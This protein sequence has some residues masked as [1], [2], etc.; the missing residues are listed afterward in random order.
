MFRQALSLDERR[1]RFKPALYRHA[2]P[3][4]ANRG[5]QPGEMPKSD[6]TVA[7]RSA[8]N[9]DRNHKRAASG[10]KSQIQHE[11]EFNSTDPDPD[12]HKT[13]VL[14]V[15]FAGDHCGTSPLAPPCR[16]PPRVLTQLCL[17]RA[18]HTQTSA[19]GT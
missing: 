12:G 13:D 14:E 7:R 9:P 6:T 8:L 18:T 2:R 19:A 15:W 16:S 10:K 4:D 17:V 5:V 1:A 3:Q 11:R